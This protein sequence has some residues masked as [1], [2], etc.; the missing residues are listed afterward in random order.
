MTATNRPRDPRGRFTRP[1]GSNNAT[2]EQLAQARQVRADRQKQRDR[3]KRDKAIA[4]AVIK[5]AKKT[6]AWGEFWHLVKFAINCGICIGLAK[7]SSTIADGAFILRDNITVVRGALDNCWANP[8]ECIQGEYWPQ[9]RAGKPIDNISA[10]LDLIAQIEGADYTTIYTGAEFTGFSKHPDR[11][12]CARGICSS[13]AGRYQFLT[14]TWERLQRKLKLPDFSP[15]SQDKAAIELLKECGGYAAAV[16]GEVEGVADRCWGTWASLKSS[17]GQKLDDRQHAYSVAE[18]KSKYQAIRAQRASIVQPLA[19]MR[20]TSRFLPSRLHPITK[21]WQPHNGSDYA[22]SLGEIVRSPIAG[23]FRRGNSDPEGFGNTW[24]SIEDNR[25]SITIGHTR[26]LL[27]EDGAIVV[28]GQPVAECGSE[29]GS[30]G[31]HLHVEIRQ[32]GALV[33]PEL[34]FRGRRD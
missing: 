21:Q 2:P 26:K 18:L 4:A 10:M 9:F 33:D 24:G 7:S 1:D 3:E 32:D 31:P 13:A 6:S 25:R 8:S 29:G 15:A 17:K 5:A 16:R 20:L 30:S 14:P 11:V 34:V 27:V 12:L 19:T 28:Q 23:T 22:C